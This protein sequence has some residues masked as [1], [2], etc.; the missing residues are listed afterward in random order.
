[1]ERQVSFHSAPDKKTRPTLSLMAGATATR[2][3]IIT[4][5]SDTAKRPAVAP[6]PVP[7]DYAL[8]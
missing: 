7:I 8:T 2:F 5:A 4:S 3:S 6:K 1:M